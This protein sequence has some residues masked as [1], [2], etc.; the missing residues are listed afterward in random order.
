MA[1]RYGAL[2]RG[3]RSLFNS[4]INTFRAV[5]DRH[6]PSTTRPS[7]LCTHRNPQKI[8][9]FSRSPVE[10][11]CAMSIISLYSAASSSTPQLSL[12]FGVCTVLSHGDVGA[13]DGG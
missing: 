7:L 5:G 9:S 12:T 2:S 13:Y 8:T 4:G 11:G 1:S 10:L 6:V 3:A